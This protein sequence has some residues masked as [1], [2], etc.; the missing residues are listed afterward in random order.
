MNEL[1]IVVPCYNERD[2]VDACHERLDRVCRQTK[3]QDYEIIFVNDGSTDETL[4]KLMALQ[5]RDPH[6][7]IV[8]LAKNHG[9]QLALSAGFSLACGARILAIDADLQDPPELLP[10]MMHLMD[11]G[12]DVVYGERVERKGESQFKKLTAKLFYRFLAHNTNV[13]IPS[14]TGD[15]RL[16]NRAVLDVLNSMPEAHRFVRGMVAW[17]GYK[18]V[19]LR[20]VRAERFA[21]TTKY[22]L[23][24][25]IK[26]AI[27]ALTAF[28]V[29]PLRFAFAIALLAAA[30]ALLLLGWSLYVYLFKNAVPGWSSLMVVFLFFTAVQ[31]FSIAIVGEYI[32]R[33]FIQTKSRPLFVIRRIYKRSP[34]K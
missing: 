22:P 19:P 8:D 5:A 29:A 16:M 27:D 28:A 11:E 6:I 3:L 30:L 25:M 2:C 31:L 21:G 33:I 14:D 20:Y 1:T 26:L 24:K 34:S 12:A 4:Y 7:V 9:H 18:Q 15:F 13:D 32:G 17:I 10:D 23:R